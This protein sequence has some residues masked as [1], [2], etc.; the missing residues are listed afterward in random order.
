MTVND[1]LQATDRYRLG[2]WRIDQGA[3]R[4]SDDMRSTKIEPRAMAVL[5]HLAANAG[6]TVTREE[7]LDEI[8]GTRHVVDEAV[9]KCISLLRQALADDRRK[10]VYIET[11]PKIGYRLLVQPAAWPV[12]PAP[13]SAPVEVNAN[14]AA[15]AVIPVRPA[16]P[17]VATSRWR[18]GGYAVGI[19]AMFAVA[20]AATALLRRNN[21]SEE[22]AQT[23]L[24]LPRATGLVDFTA[25]PL[26]V[27]ADGRTLIVALA[28]GA[29]SRLWRRELDASE[30]TP[31]A[32]TEGATSPF[33]SPDGLWIAFAAQGKIKRVGLRGGQA[34]VI[35]DSEQFFGGCWLGTDAIVFAPRFA[36][37]LWRV[38][39]S[40][41]APTPLTSQVEA[42]TA[43]IWP[44]C[45]P[46][47]RTVLFSLWR[48]G[49]NVDQSAIG[50]VTGDGRE[51]G[52]LREGAYFARYLH[53]GHLLF[54]S[55][56]SLM[57]VPFDLAARKITGPP[58][59]LFT[60][61][62][63]NVNSQVAFF[64]T[65]NSAHLALVHGR[66]EE[67]ARRLL[68]V[69][70]E[71][72]T[73]AA[74]S[75]HKPFSSPRISASG[76]IALWLQDDAVGVWVLDPQRDQLSRV[77]RA[78]D[79]HSPVW[80][81]D[82]QQLAFDSS[83]TGQYRLYAVSLSRPGSEQLL[84]D[85]PGDAFANAW[86]KDGRLVY[87]RHTI[88]SGADLF[89]LD[90]KRPGAAEPLLASPFSESEAAFSPDDRW[91]AF[92]SDESGRKEIYVQAFPI[93]G[94]RIQISR[95]GG[96]EPVWSK[97]GREVYFRSGPHMLAAEIRTQQ[98][99]HASQPRV[100]FSGSYHYN[101]YSTA[102]YDVA[103]DG[104]FLM[105]QSPGPTPRTITIVRSLGASLERQGQTAD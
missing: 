52:V 82:G 16:P 27:T 72:R 15:V 20:L 36:R 59:T 46:D 76:S 14:A 7:L 6:R 26:A 57:A 86:L 56:G 53:D 42:N 10:P 85:L 21:V 90:S 63:T 44:T 50:F 32:G 25:A 19:L 54:A 51:Q 73:T 69:D 2:P 65:S 103:P 101:L 93:A 81:P 55:V 98:E 88:E 38:S 39:I 43:H 41:G 13:L 30:F 45:L 102:T 9:T 48:G 104:R 83:R 24:P 67:P 97:D 74:S 8:W 35:A 66:Y 99:L 70:R 49:S 3:C 31:I 47:G 95:D 78:L 62:L 28:D 94:P 22:F 84:A 29:G 12:E 58:R 96:E 80:S 1:W 18:R 87:T 61:L 60:D 100:L 4:I 79:D 5:G 105:V 33:L 91:M 11:I 23:A 17:S 71:G 89:I 92:V 37:G 75:L 68:W 34:H 77:S 40:G 64:E